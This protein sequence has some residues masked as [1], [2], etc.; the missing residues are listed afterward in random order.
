[1]ED[2]ITS[3]QIEK[4]LLERLLPRKGKLRGFFKRE[5]N[6]RVWYYTMSGVKYLSPRTKQILYEITGVM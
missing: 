3:R 2:K 1:M 6:P 4:G 5:K